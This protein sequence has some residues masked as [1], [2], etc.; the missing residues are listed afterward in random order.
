M[1][2]HLQIA[3]LSEEKLVL[4]MGYPEFPCRELTALASKLR[5]VL[6]EREEDEVEQ[7]EHLLVCA[8]VA[9]RQSEATLED[10]KRGFV[11]EQKIAQA[12]ASQALMNFQLNTSYKQTH[13]ALQAFPQ[14]Q[15]Q[16]Y[17]HAGPEQSQVEQLP[18]DAQEYD[19]VVQRIRGRSISVERGGFPRECEIRVALDSSSVSCAAEKCMAISRLHESV[20]CVPSCESVCN[21]AASLQNTRSSCRSFPQPVHPLQRASHGCFQRLPRGV[22]SFQ[23][24]SALLREQG[25]PQQQLQQKSCSGATAASLAASAEQMQAL[26][27][28]A[29]VLDDTSE[30]LDCLAENGVALAGCVAGVSA[31]KTSRPRVAKRRERRP[32]K[33]YSH[34]KTAAATMRWRTQ[35]PLRS[36]LP[37][38]PMLQISSQGTLGHPAADGEEAAATQAPTIDIGSLNTDQVLALYAMQSLQTTA[39]AESSGS[40]LPS[41]QQPQPSA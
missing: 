24:A 27:D 39:V 25:E 15:Q 28:L 34:K 36:S 12:N 23:K 4:L 16:E 33:R 30:S 22:A 26:H 19:D 21:S 9:E 11:V 10:A 29:K 18:Q 31:A 14:Q 6:K 1:G 5:Q 38:V 7:L 8:V 2:I 37:Q 41:G 32:A 13:Y 40:A 17:R 3:R 20:P 35:T